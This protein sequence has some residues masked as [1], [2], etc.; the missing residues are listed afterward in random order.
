MKHYRAIFCDVDGTLL[1]SRHR[2]PDATASAIRALVESGT[3]FIMVSGRMPDAMFPIQDA[4]GTGAPMVCYG[5]ALVLDRFRRPVHS[6]GIELEVAEAVKRRVGEVRPALVFCAYSFNQWIVDDIRNPYIVG[7]IGIVDVQPEEGPI[8]EVL[9][10]GN[11]IHKVF[12]LGEP[13]D[14]DAV[15]DDL[16]E[17]FP[18]LA[19]HKSSPNYLE[20]M[21]KAVS[22]SDALRFI[23]RAMRIPVK[24][25]VAFGD[26]YNDA[27]MLAAAGLGVA[28]GNAPDAIKACAALV[29]PDNDNEGVRAVLAEL[30]FQPMS[31][32]VRYERARGYGV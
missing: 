18:L 3:P 16:R 9:T 27:D 12:C 25:S 26:N 31:H 28:M 15:H 5:G 30:S 7:E 4:L 2:L 29:A 21:N 13:A 14:I 20:I 6:I 17:R 10:P 32:S 23:C 11:E 8:A 19:I 22:K 24:E 1:D